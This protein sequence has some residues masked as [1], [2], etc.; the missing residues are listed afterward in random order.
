MDAWTDRQQELLDYVSDYVQRYNCKP[1]HKEIARHMNINTTTMRAMLDRIE[2][3]GLLLSDYGWLTI[4]EDKLKT[5]RE[6]EKHG[7]PR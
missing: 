2:N 3:K 7:N 4:P 6:R 5:K 1:T